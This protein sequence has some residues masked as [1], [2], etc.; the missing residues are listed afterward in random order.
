M[1]LEATTSHTFPF[2]NNE[3]ESLPLSTYLNSC[4]NIFGYR[5]KESAQQEIL[6]RLFS[7]LWSSNEDYR[8]LFFPN[9]FGEGP[10]AY[11][12]SLARGEEYSPTQKGKACGHVFRKGEGVYR[13]R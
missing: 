13:C 3:S 7:E 5:L 12:L 1:E 6:K 11:K 8:S 9:G 2:N 10:D 4:P